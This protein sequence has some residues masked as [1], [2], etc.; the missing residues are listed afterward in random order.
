MKILE[1]GED[2]THGKNHTVRWGGG[3]G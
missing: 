1:T 3:G 2:S